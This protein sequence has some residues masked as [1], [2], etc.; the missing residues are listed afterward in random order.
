MIIKLTDEAVKHLREIERERGDG[1]AHLRIEVEKGGCAGMQ[2]ALSFDG[3]RADDHVI[4]QGGVAVLVDPESAGYI[5]GSVI[6]YSDDLTSSGFKIQNPRA[7]RSCGCGTSF[8]TQAA[9]QA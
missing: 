7:A 8:E 4:D 6:D 2:Y 1:D 9:A 5:Q 3:K